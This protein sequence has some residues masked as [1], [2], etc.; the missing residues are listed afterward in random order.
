MTNEITK[1]YDF[2]EKEIKKEKD[3]VLKQKIKSIVKETLEKIEEIEKEEKELAEEKKILKQD[4]DNLKSGRLDL[5]EERQEKNPKARDISIFRVITKK[6][7]Y[8]PKNSLYSITATSGT[9][10]LIV[11]ANNGFYTGY[12]TATY[13]CG[14]YNLNTGT[15]KSL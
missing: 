14:T 2:A 6:I 10:P 5:I 12:T 1:A 3:E 9:I 4:I 11:D 7:E 13:T 15:I 8:P